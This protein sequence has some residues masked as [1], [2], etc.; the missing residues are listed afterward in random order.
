M[1]RRGGVGVITFKGGGAQ[2]RTRCNLCSDPR[3]IQQPIGDVLVLVGDAAEVFSTV[4]VPST[5]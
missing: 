3:K 1:E 2:L 4:D 5:D